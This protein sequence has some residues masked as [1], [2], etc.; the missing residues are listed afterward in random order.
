MACG[1]ASTSR[2]FCARSI[3][4]FGRLVV[5]AVKWSRVR[6]IVPHTRCQCNA[7]QG[8]TSGSR[9]DFVGES[10]WRHVSKNPNTFDV[11]SSASVTHG[12]R[13]FGALARQGANHRPA[14]RRG[15]VGGQKKGRAVELL[16]VILIVALMARAFRRKPSAADVGVILPALR[17]SVA[18]LVVVL[19]GMLA[20][21]G[22][23]LTLVP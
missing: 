5:K 12:L 10:D 6:C 15:G 9:P 14:Q 1:A 23:Q 3:Q 2:R 20:F 21:G 18:V 22:R 7:E 8:R 13:K 4:C 17:L 11:A 16:V 19:V